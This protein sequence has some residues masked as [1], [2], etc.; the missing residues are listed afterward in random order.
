LAFAR[1][2]IPYNNKVRWDIDIFGEPEEA[3][4]TNKVNIG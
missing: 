3:N 4:A 1:F 2:N